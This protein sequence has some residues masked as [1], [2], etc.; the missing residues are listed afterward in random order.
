M[1][2]ENFLPFHLFI[3]WGDATIWLFHSVVNTILTGGKKTTF[4]EPF[5]CWR[6]HDDVSLIRFQQP[7]ALG[8]ILS[9]L[10]ASIVRENKIPQ[11]SLRHG[12]K[13]Q[14]CGTTVNVLLVTVGRWWAA[15]DIGC[16]PAQSQ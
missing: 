10:G 11:T 4:L 12:R 16:G 14:Q 1:V 5:D 15:I 8:I 6:Q 9:L 13:E 2:R 3:T 7:R